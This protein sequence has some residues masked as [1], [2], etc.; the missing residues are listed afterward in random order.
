[1]TSYSSVSPTPGGKRYII[2]PW[3]K[4]FEM[5]VNEALT[6]SYCQEKEMRIPARAPICCHLQTKV[7]SQSND[8]AEKCSSSQF[9]LFA[10][11]FELSTGSCDDYETISFKMYFYLW[12]PNCINLLL[13]CEELSHFLETASILWGCF[14]TCVLTEA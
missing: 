3:P 11:E 7:F 1:M 9:S 2:F 14:S 13:F 8:L 5:D 12:P 10:V 6:N 4:H